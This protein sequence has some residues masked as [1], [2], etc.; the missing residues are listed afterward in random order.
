MEGMAHVVLCLFDIMFDVHGEARCFGYCKPKIQ[1][2]CCWYA[3]QADDKSPYSVHFCFGELI[4]VNTVAAKGGDYYPPY[5][6]S[7]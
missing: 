6:W 5:E 4:A 7:S 2:D 3:S 1:R